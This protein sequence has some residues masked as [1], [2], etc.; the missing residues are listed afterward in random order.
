MDEK[1]LNWPVT[2]R[3]HY[4]E[5]YSS[6]W[7]PDDL[8][9][10]VA[11]VKGFLDQVPLIHRA[12]ATIKFGSVSSYE[13]SHYVEVTIKY[14]RPPTKEEK[15]GRLDEEQRRI[16]G[17]EADERKVYERLKNKYAD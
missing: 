16:E 8:T 7:I 6:G 10:F 13:D 9:D 14:T 12:T 1:N 15:Q 5:Q 11:W 2:I 17:K 4:G 3:L